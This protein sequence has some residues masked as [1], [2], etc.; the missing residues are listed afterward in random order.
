MQFS[1]YSHPEWC[2]EKKFTK[3]EITGEKQSALTV[4]TA[5]NK[6]VID[7]SKAIDQEQF[8][9]FCNYFNDNA[10]TIMQSESFI[11]ELGGLVSSVVQGETM[12]SMCILNIQ[13]DKSGI[14][15]NILVTENKDSNN[16]DFYTLLIYNEPKTFKN[17]TV[18]AYT[19]ARVD[20]FATHGKDLSEVDAELIDYK[21]TIDIDQGVVK[22][23]KE[24]APD[25]APEIELLVGPLPELLFSGLN[26]YGIAL[27][28]G[29]VKEPVFNFTT[30]CNLF[31]DNMR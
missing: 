17:L 23:W 29:E 10:S 22:S 16:M 15:L 6:F 1:D 31:I 3:V 19:W 27:G 25:K 28:A 20:F 13:A 30:N 18:P 24:L 2:E 12:G 14:L 5:P 9:A 8:V 11:E 21:L 4:D 26:V 7:G